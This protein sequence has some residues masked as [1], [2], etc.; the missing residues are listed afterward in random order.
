MN[1]TK[2]LISEMKMGQLFAFSRQALNGPVIW[3]KKST[4]TISRINE[5]TKEIIA[6]YYFTKD[7]FGFCLE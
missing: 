6:T 1:P 2:K 5:E 4:K 7:D 3:Q